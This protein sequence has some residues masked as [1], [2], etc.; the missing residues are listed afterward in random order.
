MSRAK[1]NNKTDSWVKNR[2]GL[3]LTPRLHSDQHSV[4]SDL[5]QIVLFLVTLKLHLYE[6]LRQTENKQL[7]IQLPKK[8]KYNLTIR[9]TKKTEKEKRTTDIRRFCSIT[10]GQITIKSVLAHIG[11]PIFTIT[12]WSSILIIKVMMDAFY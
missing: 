5:N 7:N 4:R 1:E 8:D 11:M 3:T 10:G 9:Q 12:L 6:K 2:F